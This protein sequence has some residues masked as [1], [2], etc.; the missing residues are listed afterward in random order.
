[1]RLSDDSTVSNEHDLQ[2]QFK[3]C[4][5]PSNERRGEPVGFGPMLRSWSYRFN[6]L[7]V[8]KIVQCSCATANIHNDW[9]ASR[10]WPGLDEH[11]YRLHNHREII[12]TSNGVLLED[13][14]DLRFR[15][16]NN[17]LAREY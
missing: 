16:P 9:D 14:R 6:I 17:L 11:I 5:E 2:S 15:G 10:G 8:L 3:S 12:H 7:L 4:F 13:V 1:M